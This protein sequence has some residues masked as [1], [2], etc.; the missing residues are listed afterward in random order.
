MFTFNLVS[1]FRALFFTFE[2]SLAINELKREKKKV[3]ISLFIDTYKIYR[4]KKIEKK[5]EREEAQIIMYIQS[6]IH[7]LVNKI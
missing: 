2:V 3:T 6:L 7:L 5:K 4:K 1:L